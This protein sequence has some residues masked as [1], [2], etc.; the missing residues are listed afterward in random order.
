MNILYIHGFGSSVKAWSPK[1][2]ALSRLGSVTAM[3]P[4]YTE[5]RPSAIELATRTV[6]EREIE[7][8]VG[9]SLGGW[10]AAQIGVQEGLPFVALNPSIEPH[11]TLAKYMSKD[12]QGKLTHEAVNTYGPFPTH[13]RGIV[14]VELG[15]ELLSSERT[16]EVLSPYF[17]VIQFAGGTHHFEKVNDIIVPIQNFLN[18]K[19]IT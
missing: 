3:A 12:E 7:L 8:V 17:D 6:R 9:T 2:D 13:G 4:D 16:V 14:I 10:L 11:I 15:D 1:Y 19:P 18:R 5:G